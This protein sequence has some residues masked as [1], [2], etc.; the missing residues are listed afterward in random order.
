MKRIETALADLILI[1][2]QIFGDDRGYFFECYRRDKYAEL[3][4]T[5]AFVQDN[6]SRS[7]RGVLRGLHYQLGRPQAK[8]VRV[9]S[10]EIF[11][12]AVDVRRG[13]P[14]FGRHVGVLLSAENKRSLFVPEGFAHGFQ[15][16]SETAEVLYKCSD[17]YAPIEERGVLWSDPE[18][19]IAWPLPDEPTLSPKDRVYPTLKHAPT[20]DLPEYRG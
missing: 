17:L 18:L 9:L 16:L 14:T 8:L 5:C 4:V 6:Q 12:V 7:A 13:S 15:V 2:P 20:A 10:G 19:G 11:D 1:E 3:G